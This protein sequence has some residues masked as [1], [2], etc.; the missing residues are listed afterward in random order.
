[1]KEHRQLLDSYQEASWALAMERVAVHQGQQAKD[2]EEALWSD[3]QAAVPQEVIDHC[4]ATIRRKFSVPPIRRFKSVLTKVLV[5]AVVCA[6]M[7]SVAC[8]FS[9][10][11]KAFL[12]RAFYSIAEN[13]TS[14]TFQ[15]PQ[16]ENVAD[17]QGRITPQFH[18]LWFEWLPEGYAYV[19]GS[20]T[21]TSQMVEFENEQ[22]DLIRFRVANVDSVTAYNYDHNGG[23]VASVNV[24]E[25]PGQIVQ[26]ESGTTLVWVDSRQMK[27]LSIHATNLSQDKLLQMAE[28]L[29]Y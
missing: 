29:R 3:P 5:A 1:M 4:K 7:T 14:I 19:D 9:P 26:N 13:F 28:S 8:A 25:Y 22:S 20:E 16:V 23:S 10:E 18:G 12:L 21:P 6:L 11:F 15:N 24:G 17:D 27:S 2:E